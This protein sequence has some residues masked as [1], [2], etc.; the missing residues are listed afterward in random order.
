MFL[1]GRT[2]KMEEKKMNKKAMKKLWNDERAVTTQ[3]MNYI[4]VLQP[5]KDY[6]DL[7]PRVAAA[8]GAYTNSLIDLD[9]LSDEVS[10]FSGIC[11]SEGLDALDK[12]IRCIYEKDCCP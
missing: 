3:T 7:G 5:E 9:E 12:A 1:N 8:Q 11:I 2:K 6:S 4:G 10:Y